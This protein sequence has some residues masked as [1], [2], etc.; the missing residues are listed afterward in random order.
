MHADESGA[1]GYKDL[2]KQSPLK[3]S[4]FAQLALHLPLATSG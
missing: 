4:I 2:H 3:K 1:T